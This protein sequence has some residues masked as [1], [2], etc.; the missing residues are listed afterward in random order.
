MN[1][2]SPPDSSKRQTAG[3]SA[4]ARGDTGTDVDALRRHNERSDDVGGQ[5][6]TTDAA[7]GERQIDRTGRATAAG[8]DRSVVRQ[9]GDAGR[10]SATDTS[11]APRV[12]AARTPAAPADRGPLESLGR[13]VSA[14]VREA[15]RRGRRG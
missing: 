8:V 1:S 9:R 5:A 14:P 4:D 15:G 11:T 10:P 7:I 2:A 3:R 13:A 6:R 12:E